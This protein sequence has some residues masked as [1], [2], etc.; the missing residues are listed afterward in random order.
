[1]LTRKICHNGSRYIPT[2]IYMSKRSI[3]NI[4]EIEVFEDK[5][6]LSAHKKKLEQRPPFLKNLFVGKFDFEFM[7]FPQPQSSERYKQFFEW[8]KPLENY[9]ASVN[10]SEMSTKEAFQK[11]KELDILRAKID[12]K[13]D[14]LNMSEAETLKILETLGSIPW[15]ATSLIKNNIIPIDLIS[16]FGNE[17]QKENYLPRIGNGELLPT[18]CITEV[19]SGPNMKNIETKISLSDCVIAQSE[20]KKF[21]S[22]LSLSGFIVESNYGGITCSNIIHTIG[23]MGNGNA[24]LSNVYAPGNNRVAGE[25]IGILRHF[26]S[27][28][29]KNILGRKH[30]D[31]CMHEFEAVQEVVGLITCSLYCMESVA[32]FTSATNDLYENQDLELEK[33]VTETYCANECIKR[34]YEGMQVIGIE[35]YMKD[36]PYMKVYNDA[37]GLSLFDGSAIDEKIYIALLG[38]QYVGINIHEDIIKAR[39]HLLNPIHFLKQIFS[40]KKINLYLFEYTHLSFKMACTLIEQCLQ[41]LVDISTMLLEIYG[42]EISSK[43]IIL[44]KL[45]DITIQLYV[46]IAVVTRASRSYCTGIR[47]AEQERYIAMYVAQ[48]AFKKVE[49]LKDNIINNELIQHE[50]TLGKVSESAF[51]HKGY[52]CE[53][54]LKRNC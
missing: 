35:S 38:L 20:E 9:V 4:G 33:A 21:S 31:K 28:L 27:L 46:T 6:R 3:Q 36:N 24:I 34:I 40:K 25:A 11:L 13:Y 51:Q 54:P 48:Q 10:S 29:N 43:Q 37:L 44:Q 1:M 17:A 23:E 18:I 5:T 7:A 47:N 15:L 2:S 14:G 19:M 53:H 49:L 45:A 16:T 32:L 30:L 39:N 52:M 42:T 8:I 41:T 12:A 22:N 26:M 50:R